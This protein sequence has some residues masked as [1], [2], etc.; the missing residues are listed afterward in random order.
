MSSSS[1]AD[2]SLSFFGELGFWQSGTIES[3]LTGRHRDGF[4]ME[5]EGGA[6]AVADAF[7]RGQQRNR[8]FYQDSDF[9]DFKDEGLNTLRERWNIL[10]EAIN[11]M[12]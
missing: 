4:S 2:A 9:F 6:E 8:E 10:P 7:R 1:L 5:V 12:G 3:T 11:H